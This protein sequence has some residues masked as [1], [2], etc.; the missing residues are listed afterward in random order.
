MIKKLSNAYAPSAKEEEVRIIIIKE[1]EDFYTDIKVDSLGNL[2]IHKPG[3]YKSIAITAPMDEVGFLVTHEKNDKTL[4]TTSICGVKSSTLRN[5][6]LKDETD[7]SFIINKVTN[8]TDEIE[9]IR[10]IETKNI[11]MCKV[12]KLNNGFL[13]KSLIYNNTFSESDELYIGKA[14][15]R[16][17]C[18]SVLCDI[19]RS[20]VNSMYEYYFVFSAQKYCDKKGA[21]TATYNLEI[22]ELYNLCCVDSDSENVEIG[23]GPVI[24]LRDKMLISDMDLVDEFSNYSHIQKLISS[25]FISEGGYYQKQHTTQKIISVGLAVDFFGCFNEIVSKKDVNELKSIILEKALP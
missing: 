1:L 22:D 15:E 4:I 20:V 11:N 17:V 24:V 2:I 10:N 6:M 16:S 8:Y 7:N 18:C 25:N 13:S 9:K 5:S 3:K 12:K 14:L 21:L 23:K 19:A